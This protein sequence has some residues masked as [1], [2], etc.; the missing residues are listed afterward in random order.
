MQDLRY[1]DP[2]TKRVKYTLK[3]YKKLNITGFSINIISELG[4]IL[5]SS[6][7]VVQHNSEIRNCWSRKQEN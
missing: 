3:Y 1:H 5:R 4:S 2:H 7:M 6:A